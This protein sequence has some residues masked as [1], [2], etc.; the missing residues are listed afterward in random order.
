VLGRK[1][2]AYGGE[3]IFAVV[4]PNFDAIKED[5]PGREND[6]GFIRGLVKKEIEATNRSLPGYKKISDFLIRKE[7]FEKNAQQKIRRFMYKHY[8]NP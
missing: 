6:E 8:E 1:E 4:V 5:Y 3:H 7:P 2:P